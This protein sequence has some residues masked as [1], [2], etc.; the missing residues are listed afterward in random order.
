M[1]RK[2][3]STV[4]IG[5]HGLTVG[6]IKGIINIPETSNKI[7]EAGANAVIIHKGISMYGYRGYGKDL[8]LIMYL[9]GGSS[10]YKKIIVTTQK[11]LMN[12]ALTLFAFS[13]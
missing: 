5:D 7:A 12:T 13:N 1:N 2:T 6:P 9:S 3:I 11:K 10:N 8:G 4:P